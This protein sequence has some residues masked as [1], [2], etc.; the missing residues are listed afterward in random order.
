[1]DKTDYSTLPL[2]A[3]GVLNRLTDGGPSDMDEAVDMLWVLAGALEQKMQIIK[4][5]ER[6]VNRKQLTGLLNDRGF[7]AEIDKEEKRMSRGQT[8]GGVVISI[9]LAGFKRINDDYNMQ[10]GDLGL[11]K[12][13]DVL[14]DFG[15]RDTDIIGNPGGD[16]FIIIVTDTELQYPMASDGVSKHFSEKSSGLWGKIDKLNELTTDIPF[17]FEYQD[18]K[19]GKIEFIEEELNARISLADYNENKPIKA[20]LA[21]ADEKAKLIKKFTEQYVPGGR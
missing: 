21:Q 13:A 18:P 9:D 19:T 7:E 11:Q 2:D 20:A 12:F 8:K 6:L 5:L 16:E 14:K 17:N 10:V 4:T 15:F 3:I 1:M